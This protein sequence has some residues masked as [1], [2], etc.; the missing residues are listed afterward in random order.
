MTARGAFH[1]A[2]SFG[3]GVPSTAWQSGAKWSGCWRPT[4]AGPPAATSVFPCGHGRRISAVRIDDAETRRNLC[5][6]RGGTVENRILEIGSE[7]QVAS[8]SL[9]WL[10]KAAARC[11]TYPVAYPGAQMHPCIPARGTLDAFICI[12][13]HRRVRSS[14][15]RL[16]SLG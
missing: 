15:A 8:R 4:P 6:E 10:N 16:A 3:R 1:C 11:T 5:V 14:C 7:S 12:R 13:N 2:R 9:T